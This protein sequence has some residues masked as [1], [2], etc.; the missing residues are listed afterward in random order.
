MFKSNNIILLAIYSTR[1]LQF[2]QLLHFSN[3][4]GLWCVKCWMNQQSYYSTY[5]CVFGWSNKTYCLKQMCSHYILIRV[6][7]SYL[8]PE[9]SCGRCSIGDA[10]ILIYCVCYCSWNIWTYI[11]VFSAQYTYSGLL[12]HAAG[13]WKHHQNHNHERLADGS[14]TRTT[15]TK[16]WLMEASLEPNYKR[17]ADGNITE[18]ISTKWDIALVHIQDNGMCTPTEDAYDNAMQQCNQNNT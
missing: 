7:W 12:W 14:I 5:K 11:L 8:K 18:T 1:W 9:F 15:S 10:Q 13:W 16:V 4:C 6:K 2:F 17:L 3:N